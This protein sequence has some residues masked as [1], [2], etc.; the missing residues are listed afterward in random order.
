M[1]AFTVNATQGGGTQRRRDLT[2]YLL[3]ESSGMQPGRM[4]CS[5]SSINDLIP[6]LILF[7]ITAIILGSFPAA[8]LLY[9]L[10]VH[11][12]KERF[13]K[14]FGSQAISQRTLISKTS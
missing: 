7:D 2:E 10:N 14:C 6:A 5:R 11:E 1:V 13:R 9:A 12:V 4:E 8:N 3:C